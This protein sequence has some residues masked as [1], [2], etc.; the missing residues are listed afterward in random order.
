[1]LIADDL[2]LA[3]MSRGL[4]LGGLF[5]LAGLLAACGGAADTAEQA[6]G[7]C[8]AAPPALGCRARVTFYCDA[9]TPS[10]D[11]CAEVASDTG[12]SIGRE[13]CCEPAPAVPPRD[14]AAFNDCRA[15]TGSLTVCIDGN[16]ACA[17][18]THPGENSS[19]TCRTGEPDVW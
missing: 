1:M 6:G 16:C 12:T 14:C 18:P 3:A 11:G 5:A 15:M 7:H 17:P 2:L 9:P 8:T 13:W 19:T 4:L 10:P